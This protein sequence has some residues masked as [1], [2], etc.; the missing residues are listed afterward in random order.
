[1]VE[2]N[3][4]EGGRRRVGGNMTTDGTFPPVGPDDH[5]HG[6]PP[7]DAL[8]APL[9]FPV[10]RE[11]NL[12][13]ARDGVDVGRVGREGNL[14]PSAVRVDPQLMEKL[15]DALGTL[16]MEHIV[17]RLQPFPRFLH[18]YFGC[19]FTPIGIVFFHG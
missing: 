18:I 10:A 9:G 13:L 16:A 4:E 11:R 1:M 6:V 5:G 14:H 15:P 3:L 8:N 7:D 12:S 2:P 19:D 17:E